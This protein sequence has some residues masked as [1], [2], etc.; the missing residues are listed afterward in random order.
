MAGALITPQDVANYLQQDASMVRTEWADSAIRIATGWLRGRCHFEQWPP[1]P[2]PED[3]WA[4][5]VEL[6]ALVY[7]NPTL[8]SSTTVG[9]Q[10]VAYGAVALRRKQIL[11]EAEGAYPRLAGR[12]VG[13]F[14]EA[15]PLPKQW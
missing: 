5:L 13:E 4:W 10:T 15:C 9:G 7:D 3:V 2:V 1:D 12:P 6:A 11:D 8:V 14:P